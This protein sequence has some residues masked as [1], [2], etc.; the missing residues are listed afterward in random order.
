[1]KLRVAEIVMIRR[2]FHQSA[3]SKIR[4]PLGLLDPGDEDFTAAPILFV[5]SESVQGPSGGDRSYCAALFAKR[6]GDSIITEN[7]PDADLAV[8]VAKLWHRQHESSWLK[9]LFCTMGL[10]NCFLARRSSTVFG[11]RK[12]ELTE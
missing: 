6:E 12:R 9:G 2:L 7:R 11:V 4:P 1:M 10:Q 3:G 5:G 8:C